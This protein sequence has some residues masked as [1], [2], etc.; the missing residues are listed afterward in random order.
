METSVSQI[1]SNEG[2]VCDNHYLYL[3]SRFPLASSILYF[4][5]LDPLEGSLKKK[6]NIVRNNYH[7]I[8][9]LLFH[10]SRLEIASLIYFMLTLNAFGSC[11]NFVTRRYVSIFSQVIVLSLTI[12]EKIRKQ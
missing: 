3:G 7:H 12:L 10:L 2:K 11:V 1:Y 6:D 4:F 5:L 8:F 9:R